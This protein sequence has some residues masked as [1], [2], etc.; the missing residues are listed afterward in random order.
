MNRQ[1]SPALTEE[2]RESGQKLERAL[3]YKTAA[4]QDRYAERPLRYKTAT[5]KELRDFLPGAPIVNRHQVMPVAHAS[6]LARRKWLD[7]FA[8]DM[9]IT[10][11][12]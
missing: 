3:R 11:N 5:L 10:V 4:L 7:R 9:N 12:S 6:A 1:E 8:Q 2:E